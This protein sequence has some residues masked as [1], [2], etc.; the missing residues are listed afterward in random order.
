MNQ[1]TNQIFK[2]IINL[3]N[4]HSAEQQTTRHSHKFLLKSQLS[5]NKRFLRNVPLLLLIIRI[6][7]KA[8][9]AND[10]LLLQYAILIAFKERLCG[11][12][13]FHDN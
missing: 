12:T 10:T 5:S 3:T 8:V 13:A 2:T 9:Y 6:S 4:T 11:H 1:Q 7:A